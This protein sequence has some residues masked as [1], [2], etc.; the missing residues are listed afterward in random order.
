MANW[1][2]ESFAGKMFRLG[3]RYVP[4][5]VEVPAPVLWGDPAV[6]RLRFSTYGVEVETRRR[7]IL[8]DYP[9]SPAEVVEFFREHFGPTRVAFGRLDEARQAEFRDD[10]EKLWSES[11]LA[12]PAKTLIEN[13]YLEVIGVRQ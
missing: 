13:E 2:P 12:G 6:V 3:N 5:P 9:G 1:T 11:N 4:P 10:L 7:K 8:F